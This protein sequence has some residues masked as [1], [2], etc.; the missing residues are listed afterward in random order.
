LNVAGHIVGPK[1]RYV[2]AQSGARANSN[3]PISRQKPVFLLTFLIGFPLLDDMVFGIYSLASGTRIPIP[4][5]VR[6]DCRSKLFF[7]TLSS[8]SL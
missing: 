8:H 5:R 2:E 6:A 1:D 4:N 3:V 7:L